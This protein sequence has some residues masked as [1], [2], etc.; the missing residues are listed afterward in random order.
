MRLG[1]PKE[2]GTQIRNNN[3]LIITMGDDNAYA[4][5]RD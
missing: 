5:G 4:N 3:I 2:F 1:K